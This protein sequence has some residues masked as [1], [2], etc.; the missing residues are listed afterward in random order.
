L[1]VFAYDANYE[2]SAARF[3]K[4]TKSQLPETYYSVKDFEGSTYIPYERIYGGTRL[5]TDS[6]GLFFDLYTDGLPKGR[7][8]TIDYF[9]IDKGTQYIVEDKNTKFIVE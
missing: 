2:P 4:P 5:S 9:V 6:G 8:L 1:R 3:S 7:L